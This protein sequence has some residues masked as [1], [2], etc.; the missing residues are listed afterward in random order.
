MWRIY[1]AKDDV[2]GREIDR[3]VPNTGRKES[4]SLWGNMKWMIQFVT[5]N[6]S[7]RRTRTVVLTTVNHSPD[8]ASRLYPLPSGKG[9]L[10]LRDESGKQTV[11]KDILKGP[12]EQHGRYIRPISSVSEITLVNVREKVPAS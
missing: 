1:T 7:V 6:G 4:V 5:A 12:L 2:H 3:F 11:G 10:E 9:R 8:S